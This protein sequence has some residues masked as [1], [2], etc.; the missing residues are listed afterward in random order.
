M[1]LR[2]QPVFGC[3][4]GEVLRASALEGFGVVERFEWS[5]SADLRADRLTRVLPNWS[6]P[7]ADIVA[8]LNPHAV[9]AL[10]V[11]KFVERLASEISAPPMA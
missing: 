7:D 2:I 10:G 5:V 6:F 3:N 1:N 9:R 8:L 4:N 11:G